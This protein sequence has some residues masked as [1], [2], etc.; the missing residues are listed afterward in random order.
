M[1]H[2]HLKLL[3]NFL[4]KKSTILYILGIIASFVICIYLMTNGKVPVFDV[5]N[6]VTNTATY[7]EEGPAIAL[8]VGLLAF[9]TSIFTNYYTSEKNKENILMQLEHDKRLHFHPKN[10][11]TTLDLIEKLISFYEDF[12]IR[13]FFKPKYG[14]DFDINKYE[15]KI[16]YTLEEVIIKRFGF[17]EKNYDEKSDFY[18]CFIS[19]YGGLISKEFS[20]FY[21]NPK[22]VVYLNPNLRILIGAWQINYNH[23]KKVESYKLNLSKN[24]N[25]IKEKEELYYSIFNE[26]IEQVDLKTAYI[27][28]FRNLMK[29]YFFLEDEQHKVWFKDF[30]PKNIDNMRDPFK[31]VNPNFFKSINTFNL[32]EIEL[33]I[34]LE[35]V[36]NFE[37][38]DMYL[39]ELID[40]FIDRC[41]NQSKID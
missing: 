37:T 26:K 34:Q 35:N 5:A 40:E 14:K 38:Q 18:R 8:L 11:E 24:Q 20:K 10:E 41:M 30:D 3:Y 22:K 28:L 19:I 6:N 32:K 15:H 31:R 1:L 27:Q 25:N 29:V 33:E 21:K 36:F 17:F 13:Y 7:L 2:N 16:D 39:K 23:I 12:E 4:V 9:L